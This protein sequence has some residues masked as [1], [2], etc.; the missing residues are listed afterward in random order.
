ML[1]IEF[2]FAYYSFGLSGPRDS[3]LE[4]ALCTRPGGHAAVLHQER[5]TAQT[6]T[7]G[8]QKI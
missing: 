2:I 1:G 3:T 6:A 7:T 5:D 8:K 4:T